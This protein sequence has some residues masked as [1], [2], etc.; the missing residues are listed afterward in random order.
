MG[1]NQTNESESLNQSGGFRDINISEGHILKHLGPMWELMQANRELFSTH[2]ENGEIELR[3]EV[4]SFFKQLKNKKESVNRQGVVLSGDFLGYLFSYDSSIEQSIVLTDVRQ[5]MIGTIDQ[6][7]LNNVNS[8]NLIV[9]GGLG[10]K[11]DPYINNLSAM[12]DFMR[13]LRDYLTDVNEGEIRELDN[14]VNR[15]RSSVETCSK[16][17]GDLT[18]GQ[19]DKNDDGQI[20]G[21]VQLAKSFENLFQD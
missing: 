9:L 20:N 7:M 6:E 8:L 17:L 10:R 12:A 13:G 4:E 1:E 3:P 2:D 14:T 18:S 21:V 19:R 16:T 11:L 5:R 15:F